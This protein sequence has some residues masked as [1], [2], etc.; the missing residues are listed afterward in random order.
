MNH[1]FKSV[2]ITDRS[3][4]SEA[5]RVAMSAALSLGFSE[6]RRSDVGIVASEAANNICLHAQTGE[7][8]VC[9][10][11]SE[12][13]TWLD[14]LALDNG[15]GISDVSRA[16]EDG[17]STAGTHGQ[18]LGAIQRLSDASSLYSLAHRGSVLWSR[19]GKTRSL[20]Y[21]H[22][23]VVSVPIHGETACGDS[24]VALPDASK[25]LYMMVDGLG[26]GIHA[27]EAANEAVSV[28]RASAGEATTEILTRVHGALKKTRG[29]AMS[30][31][32]V[33]YERQMAVCSGVGNITTAVMT[34][35]ATRNVPSQNGTLGAVLPRIQEYTYPIEPHSTLMMY[36][37]GLTSKC[38][39][40]GYP[41]LQNRHPQLIAGLLYRD[42]SRRRDDATV[43]YA[44]LGGL[45]L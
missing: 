19:L 2:A 20:R 12:N 44:P 41:G 13:A 31:V 37:D 43:L 38:S 3:S 34:G 10:F 39:L 17:Y 7:V 22:F 14:L 35:T 26:H 36:S 1:T 33:D 25:S 8:L 11:E 21:P 4:V 18:G 6:Q 32:L 24:F 15:P 30:L 29:A 28:V 9:S 40:T 45:E 16:F 5:R 42:F 23:G 27:A